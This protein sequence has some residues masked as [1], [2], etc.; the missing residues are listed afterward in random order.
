M[1]KSGVF[2]IGLAQLDVTVGDFAGN[3][4]KMLT[5]LDA[6]R[7][8]K[9]D[10]L[11]FP[12]LSVCGYP[13]E[14]LLLKPSFIER[15]GRSLDKLSAASRGLT[16]VAGFVEHRGGL[17]NAAAIIHDG[18]HVGTYRKI[19]LP[20]YGVFDEARYFKPGVE[21][22]VFTIAGVKVG[23]S[24]C[25]D[26]WYNDGPSAAQVRAGAEILLNIS[27]SPYHYGRIRQRADTL[28]A[29]ARDSSAV[30]A[31]CNMVG[32]QDELVFDGNSIVLDG[33]GKVL[34]RGR[35]FEEDLVVADIE[36]Q[37]AA[38]VKNSNTEHRTV[39]DVPVVPVSTSA[40]A[41]KPLLPPRDVR[42]LSLV[43]EIYAA[44]LL[45]TRD[46]IAKNGFKKV[47]LGLSGGVDSAL[48]A[49]IAVDA[50]G[51]ENV[52]GISMPSRY[53]SPGSITDAE[54]LAN[55]LGIKLLSLPIEEVFSS[56]LNSLTAVFGDT[57][58]GTSE[59][60]LQARIR[61]NFVM[62]LSNKFG[63]LVLPTGNKSEMATGYATLYG[64]MAGGF[65]ILKDVPKTL[66][67]SLVAY[68]N[69]S[70]GYDL[71]P[72]SVIE[73]PP[74]AELR[75]NQRDIDSLPPYEV[76]DQ[77]LKAYV[78][79]DRSVEQMLAVGLDEGAVRRAV[80]LVDASEYKRRQAP[81]GIK[82]TARAFG[83]DR[84]LPITNKFRGNG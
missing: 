45:G 29:R 33:T 18:R 6:A 36:I 48:V 28:M 21:C 78:E 69:R 52:I 62:A 80:S 27:A 35:A 3:L 4:D 14:D 70:A 13:P 38:C 61:G 82:I 15:I 43:E 23:V 53:S 64:D 79:E 30:V 39:W 9:I 63:W 76:L 10:V 17:Y 40:G 67:Y 68:R 73:K 83:R 72:Q 12:E 54:K 81:P 57:P 11:A 84:R 5:V 16:V 44:L 26:I 24:I 41:A 42:D 46:Y 7:G 55:N 77:V 74:S 34:A 19:L 51:K 66:V 22:P 65:A 50:L 2:R 71:I 49:A 58:A 25:E 32:G 8:L 59:E 56:Y 47:V 60:N 75:P 1:E 37:S 20:N 31:Y